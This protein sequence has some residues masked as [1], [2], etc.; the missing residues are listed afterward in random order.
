MTG[1][2][3]TAVGIAPTTSTGEPVLHD[4]G[5]QL[6]IDL[7]EDAH[8]LLAAPAIQLA[9]LFPQLPDQLDLPT[10]PQQRSGLRCAEP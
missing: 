10:D 9:V 7:T 5:H 3:Q 1:F 8:A 2:D 4:H 6:G